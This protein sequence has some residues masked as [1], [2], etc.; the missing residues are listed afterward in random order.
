M[1]SCVNQKKT[2]MKKLRKIWVQQ[3][4]LFYNLNHYQTNK[5]FN[6]EKRSSM[7]FINHEWFLCTRSRGLFL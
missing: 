4:T 2:E 1:T 7:H 5:N 3:S 6:T